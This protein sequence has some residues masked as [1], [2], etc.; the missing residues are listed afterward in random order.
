MRLHHFLIPIAILLAVP[1]IPQDK[2]P[3]YSIES[4]GRDVRDVVHM[5]FTQAKKSYIL[6][7]NTR[8]ALYL[9]L[10]DTDFETAF[11]LLRQQAKLQYE[12]R[13]GVYFIAAMPVEVSKVVSAGGPTYNWAPILGKKL[14]LHREKIA[15]RNAFTAIQNQTNVRIEVDRAIPDYLVNVAFDEVSLKFALDNLTKAAQLTYLTGKDGILRISTNQPVTMEDDK[16]DS[17]A[18]KCPN[19]KSMIKEG[20]KYCPQCGNWVKPITG[21]G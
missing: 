18:L 17:A 6:D 15:L 10:Y 8:Q 1:A 21:K 4:A 19:C 11:A 2:A 9:T 3:T 20:W 16:A 14:T 13:E 7:S 12:V 5:L